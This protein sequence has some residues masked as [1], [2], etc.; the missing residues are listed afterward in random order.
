MVNIE[1]NILKYN[2]KAIDKH[3]HRHNRFLS[4]ETISMPSIVKTICWLRQKRFNILLFTALRYSTLVTY[5]SSVFSQKW[6]Q[7]IHSKLTQN[8]RNIKHQITQA[9]LTTMLRQPCAKCKQCDDL[10]PSDDVTS[11]EEFFRELMEP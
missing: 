5:P 3:N 11:N 7:P 9:I 2:S 6:C 4:P 8:S 10:S 1:E